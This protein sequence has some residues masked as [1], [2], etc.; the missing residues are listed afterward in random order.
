M[1]SEPEYRGPT[2]R[3][4][5]RTWWVVVTVVVVAVVAMAVGGVV[6]LRGGGSSRSSRKVEDLPE[7]GNEMQPRRYRLSHGVDA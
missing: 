7:P 1:N 6:L 5:R 3:G 4:D 2:G